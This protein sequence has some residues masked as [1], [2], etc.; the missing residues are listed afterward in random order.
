MIFLKVKTGV[1]KAW[2]HKGTG[3]ILVAVT[4]PQ[5]STKSKPRGLYSKCSALW[6]AFRIQYSRTVLR[7]F[8]KK[9]FLKAKTPERKLNF[10]F[11]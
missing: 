11:L 5:C 6:V 1:K 3:K 9:L 2:L 8:E 4:G 7:I 10:G